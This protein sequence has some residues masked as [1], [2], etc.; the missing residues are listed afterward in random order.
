MPGRQSKNSECG[1]TSD[2]DVSRKFARDDPSRANSGIKRATLESTHSMTPERIGGQMMATHIPIAELPTVLDGRASAC[3]A[4]AMLKAYSGDSGTCVGPI[5]AIGG[6]V[7]TPWVWQS[8]EAEWCNVLEDYSQ[9]GVTSFNPVECA[10]GT[11][12][13]ERVTLPLRNLIHMRLTKTLLKYDLL[14]VWAAVVNKDWNTCVTSEFLG[15]FSTPF[16][17]C[18]DQII[19][20]LYVW[21]ATKSDVNPIAP[22]FSIQTSDR[23]GVEEDHEWYLRHSVAC[24]RVS[25]QTFECP[26]RIVPLQMAGLLAHEFYKELLERPEPKSALLW[27]TRSAATE[28]NAISNGVCFSGQAM[29]AAVERRIT[30]IRDWI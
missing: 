13:F 11:A 6:F 14:P 2:L 7:G 23:E 30:K 16:D 20:Q 24:R 15:V 10:T 1:L 25:R 29:K 5:S 28:F 26:S 4:F 12:Q 21:S 27:P 17:L 3:S 22:V 18:Y 19:R 9:Y 8:A